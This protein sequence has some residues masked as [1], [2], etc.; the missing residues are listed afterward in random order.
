MEWLILL[1][2][3][4]VLWVFSP[5]SP[6][7][8]SFY[9]GRDRGG[10]PVGFWLLT[11]SVF[12]SWIF[13]KSI[14]N[15]ANLGAVYGLPGGLAYA[16]WY[17]SIPLAG[18]VL[19]LIRKHR[20]VDSLSAFLMN[21]Y[22]RFATL[23]FLVAVF[24]RLFNEIWSN[25]MVVGTYFGMKGSPPY[26]LACFLFTVITL[27]YSLRGGLR[28]SIVTDGIQVVLM[29]F[30]LALVLGYILPER[31]GRL[32]NAGEFSM[33]GGLDLLLVGLLQSLSYPFHDPLLTDR[34]FISDR[35]TLLKSFLAAGF[36]GMIC[37]TVFSFVGV[38]AYIGGVDIVDDAPPQV[39]SSLGITVLVMMNII[40]LSSA[41][42]T[43]DSTFSS[44]ARE[45]ALDVPRLS[46]GVE[47][48]RVSTGRWVMVCMAVVGN[49]PLFT[50]ATILQATTISGTMV[51]GLAPIFLFYWWDRPGATSFHLAFWFGLGVGLYEVFGMTP[52]VLRVGDGPYAGLLGLNLWGLIGCVFV[53]FLGSYLPSLGVK[54]LR[55]V[56]SRTGS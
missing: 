19:Y 11:G 33:N 34:G 47:G 8:E 27:A 44:L 20:D 54:S 29:V 38:H 14:T 43:V 31:E 16:A 42:S 23:A 35:V 32:L 55:L 51:M 56:S 52:A 4:A 39:A 10:S 40:M 1:A 13:A 21:K 50:G 45:W 28:S 5:R 2:Y 48:G 3:G 7:R 53:F 12:I 6:D 22:G 25:T 24:I 49:I 26:Y 17:C 46:S 18:V 41:G 30:F 36:A 9:E 15:A 37:I